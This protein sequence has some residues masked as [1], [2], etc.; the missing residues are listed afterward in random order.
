MVNINNQEKEVELD[1]VA[2]RLTTKK[3]FVNMQ[4]VRAKSLISSGRIKQIE[5]CFGA[6]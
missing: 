4:F 1:S 2:G 6:K 5:R 3:T